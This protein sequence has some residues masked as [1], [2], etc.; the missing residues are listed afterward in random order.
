VDT[1]TAPNSVEDYMLAYKTTR[2]LYQALKKLGQKTPPSLPGLAGELSVKARLSELG[3]PFQT[4]GGQAGYDILLTNR[5]QQNHVEVRTS[6]PKALEGKAN[7]HSWKVQKWKEKGVKFDFLVCV[8]LDEELGN[9]QFYVFTREEALN[10]RDQRKGQF[11]SVRK[12]IHIYASHEELRKAMTADPNA[13]AAW[14]QEVN[15]NKEKYRN[16]WQIL[17]T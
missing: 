3:I 2:Q 11:T 16:R 17:T 1:M 12:R 4:K 7:G 14:E 8:A 9:P 6:R 5:E 15:L 10:A 13:V